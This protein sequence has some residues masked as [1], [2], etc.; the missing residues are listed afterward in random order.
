M[1][2]AASKAG[3]RVN[4]P[5]YSIDKLIIESLVDNESLATLTINDV[6]HN[7]FIEVASDNDLV[8]EDGAGKHLAKIVYRSL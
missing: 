7:E 5:V 2:E 3:L 4:L 8:I 6:I 1:N